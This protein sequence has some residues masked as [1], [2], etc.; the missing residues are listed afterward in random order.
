[1]MASITIT[2]SRQ[3]PEIDLASLFGD[4]KLRMLEAYVIERGYT[5]KRNWTK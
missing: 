5:V 3:K 1:M 2:Q 4:N